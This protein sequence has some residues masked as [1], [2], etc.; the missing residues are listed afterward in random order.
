MKKLKKTSNDKVNLKIGLFKPEIKCSRL[1][2]NSRVC[3]IDKFNE[4]F[5]II[6]ST[7]D[8]KNLISNYCFNN[9]TSLVTNY[10]GF[11]K[12]YTYLKV[13]I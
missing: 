3:N 8:F 10:S 7:K 12:N 2:V 1:T 9:L 6:D 5:Q 13:T 11:I 4:L